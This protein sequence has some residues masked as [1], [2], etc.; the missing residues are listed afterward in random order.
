MKFIFSTGSL[1][2]Y[3]IA[4]VFAFAAEAGF[5]GVELMADYRWDTRQHHHILE[6]VQQHGLPV[7]ALHS[8]FSPVPGWG[9]VQPEI[10]EKSV[11]LAEAIDA[12]VLIHHLP[13]K[14]KCIRVGVG[15]NRRLTLPVPFGE[16]ERSYRR[17]LEK[18]HRQLQ[19][20]TDVLLC[21]ENMPAIR[22]FG[23]RWNAYHWNAR[24]PLHLN[25]I[26][27]FP[28]LTMDTTHLAT[29]GLEASTVYRR[30]RQQVQHVHL[31]NFDG[32]EHRRPEVGTIRLDVL[33][34]E[35]AKDGYQ[36]SI[37][38]ELHPD[39]LE[40][41]APDERIVELMAK[42]LMWCRRWAGQL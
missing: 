35:M 1:Y 10:I 23:Y 27:R 34:E 20:R 7:L 4:R 15:K 26:C 41:G 22:S 19:E 40:D 9:K 17:W 33:L 14:T 24:D 18:G 42:S 11:T 12:P 31:S 13:M 8:P 37:S 36:R 39:A 21:V 5:D 2:T 29:W 6:L 28:N 32:R 25:D 16:P 38:L 30:W 3:S